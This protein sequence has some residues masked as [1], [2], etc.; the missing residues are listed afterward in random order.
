MIWVG[1]SGKLMQRA[2]WLGTILLVPAVTAAPAATTFKQWPIVVLTT[3][4]C[5]AK[6]STRWN[7]GILLYRLRVGPLSEDQVR[8]YWRTGQFIIRLVDGSGFRLADVPVRLCDTAVVS[9]GRTGYLVV[10]ANASIWCA[11]DQ[12]QQFR[13]WTLLNNLPLQ[14]KRRQSTLIPSETRTQRSPEAAQ[15]LTTREAHRLIKSGVSLAEV[16]K[17]SD[18][19]KHALVEVR[20]VVYACDEQG[21]GVRITLNRLQRDSSGVADNETGDIFVI[22]APGKLPKNTVDIGRKVRV[23]ARILGDE[24]KFERLELVAVMSDEE[25][26]KIDEE[27]S[28]RTGLELLRKLDALSR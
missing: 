8:D 5:E 1:R 19:W 12:Y 7:Q 25:A 11:S 15:Y 2:L 9:R 16:T 4:G 26:S 28:T 13:H 14:V 20:G 3:G 6:L 24:E 18:L 17:N 23:L 21:A 10:E 27:E 22:D